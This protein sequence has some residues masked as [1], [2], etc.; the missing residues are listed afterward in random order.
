MVTRDDVIL[1]V[2]LDGV[3]QLVTDSRKS[4]QALDTVK[5][6]ARSTTATVPAGALSNDA[7]IAKT[8]ADMA[9]MEAQA[10]SL[11][12]RVAVLPGGSA[13]AAEAAAVRAGLGARTRAVVGATG[14]GRLAGLAAPFGGVG[15]LG[16]LGAGY[17][18]TG[19]LR[20]A[21]QHQG[22]V[23]RLDAQTRAGIRST[24]G[25]AGVTAKHIDELATSLGKLAGVQDE[26]VHESENVLLTFT[27]I[28][29]TPKAKIFDETS[30]AVAN[31]AARMGT[32]MP[33]AALQLG[34]ALN[35]PVGGLGALRRIGVQFTKSQEDQIKVQIAAG[36]AD[37][38]RK[39]ILQEL[40]REFGHSA[41]EAGK[42][43][44]AAMVNLGEAWEDAR[45]KLV[46]GLLPQLTQLTNFLA[47]KIPQAAA[48]TE[49]VFDELMGHKGNP[50]D[51]AIRRLPGGNRIA[52]A[53][54]YIG[55]NSGL[56]IMRDTGA[57]FDTTGGIFGNGIFGIPG[58]DFSAGSRRRSR[59]AQ[60][61]AER[62]RQRQAVGGVMLDDNGKVV[63]E[64]WGMGGTPPVAAPVKVQAWDVGDPLENR[65]IYLVVD[66]QV[67]AKANTKGQQKRTHVE[68]SGTSRRG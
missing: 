68:G 49:S 39:I 13:S 27:K 1:R 21:I 48:I 12:Q 64:G 14:L 67:L 23:Q 57:G 30:L 52:D 29:N 15:V 5:A 66:G 33:Q 9:R 37:D 19:Q 46:V 2:R 10:A 59:D 50:I 43:L 44:P 26:T 17:L 16:G 38:A 36:R 42:T 11:R 54:A 53:Y 55:T 24:G 41:E 34:K 4:A 62:V 45:D 56:D 31:V 6:S 63:G 51:K 60:G 20:A 18:A 58:T 28:R 8:K 35:D 40:N 65:P 61:L 25:A 32:D 47:V 7:W 3:P 22:E